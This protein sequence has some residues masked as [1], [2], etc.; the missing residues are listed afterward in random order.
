[1]FSHQNNGQWNMK[2]KKYYQAGYISEW[3]VITFTNERGI[4]QIMKGLTECCHSRGTFSP[5]PIMETPIT[6]LVGIFRR[7][8]IGDPT[9]TGRLH[10]PRIIPGNPQVVEVRVPASCRLS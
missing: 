3:A 5:P 7:R 9:E 4:E 6:V 2:D 8:G 10:L 1:M